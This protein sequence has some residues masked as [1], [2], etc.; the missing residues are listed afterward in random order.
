MTRQRRLIVEVVLQQRGH[1]T[2]DTIYAHVA[3][4]DPAINLATVYR[5]L[6]RLHQAGLLRTLDAGQERLLFEVADAHA[7]HHHLICT[8]C[9]SQLEIDDAAIEALRNVLL[10]RYNFAA[11]PEH[12][13]IVGRCG[14]CR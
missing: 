7:Q 12:L 4:R 11:E 10:Q 3:R 9:G 14:R 6:H 1:F 8:Q 13:A 5:T 2:V